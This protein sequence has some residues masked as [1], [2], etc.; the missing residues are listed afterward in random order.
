M[1]AHLRHTVTQIRPGDGRARERGRRGGPGSLKRIDASAAS[2][3]KGCRERHDTRSD[4]TT[5]AA[6]FR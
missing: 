6:N 5:P 4:R 2:E 1:H 3:T